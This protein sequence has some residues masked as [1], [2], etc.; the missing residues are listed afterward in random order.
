MT[1]EEAKQCWCPFAKMWSMADNG[2][3]SGGWNRHPSEPP[4]EDGKYSGSNCIGS[5][6]MVW[7]WEYDDYRATGG[8]LEQTD[9]GYCGLAAKP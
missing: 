3:A 9:S 2:T 8:G 1:E 4:T 6:C 5:K 7:R